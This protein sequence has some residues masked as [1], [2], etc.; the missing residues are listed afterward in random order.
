M[1][2]ANFKVGDKVKVISIPGVDIDNQIMIL[3]KILRLLSTNLNKEI[4]HAE[5]FE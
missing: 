5:E 1:Q 4:K 2:E 3:V